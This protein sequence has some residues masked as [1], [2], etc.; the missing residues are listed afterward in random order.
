MRFC[1]LLAIIF[2]FNVSQVHAQDMAKALEDHFQVYLIKPDKRSQGDRVN[3]SS[4]KAVIYYWRSLDKHKPD[5]LI[6]DAYEWLLLGRTSY[7]KGAKEAF[8]K[9]PT[10]ST[11]ELSFYDLEFGTKKGTHRAEILPSQTVV[12]YL[13]VGVRKDSLMKKSYNRKKIKQMMKDKQ[14]VEVGKEYVDTTSIN[15]AYM[16]SKK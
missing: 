4:D 6:C 1:F 7:G 2:A 10:L 14:C 15:D 11:I 12:E 9:Y 5:E 3:I 8:D 13:R 16:R